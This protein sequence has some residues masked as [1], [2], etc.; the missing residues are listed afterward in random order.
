MGCGPD[1]GPPPAVPARGARV[2]GDDAEGADAGDA[3]PG[4]YGAAHRAHER[5][6][7]VPRRL[8][9]TRHA[10]GLTNVVPLRSMGDPLDKLTV[11]VP[12]A[13]ADRVRGALAEAGA[14]RIG[15]YGEASF[16]SPGE[17]RFRP[18]EGANPTIGRVGDL[19]VVGEERVE[20][21]VD[22]R[23]RTPVI[24]AM[25]AAHPYE[26]PAWDVV[27]L[28][29]AGTALTGAGRVGDVE[30]T[31]LTG[32]RRRRTPPAARDRARRAGGG[33]SR[34]RRT[35]RGRGRRG[36]RLPARGRAAQRRRRV[37]DQR[38]EAPP[39]DRVRRA[40]RS[41]SR[42]RLALGGRVDVAAAG[43]G[44]APGGARYGGDPREHDLHRRLAVP[45]S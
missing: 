5:R 8:R 15:E 22:R 26:T 10:L 19:E 18:L 4:G 42:R 7:R 31:T 43:G 35:S 16:S 12:L 25:L 45:R 29:D 13:D 3:G 9:R 28:A 30:A 24:R 27:E 33:R 6:P 11:Y 37:R 23:L 41:G 2:R 32:L 17:G 39:G 20:V 34:P 14:G 21:V 40:G 44:P 36:R 1:G 38:P